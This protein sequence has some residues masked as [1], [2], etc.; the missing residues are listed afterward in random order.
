MPA[1]QIYLEESVSNDVAVMVAGVLV[2]VAAIVASVMSK[3]AFELEKHMKRLWM[4]C[5]PEHEG[6]L[7][8]PSTCFSS[9]WS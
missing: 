1:L 3:A 5:I 9:C 4:L 6:R 2:T 8:A 7:K